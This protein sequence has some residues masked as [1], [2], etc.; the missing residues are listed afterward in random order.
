MF[1]QGHD[2]TCDYTLVTCENKGCDSK[3]LRMVLQKHLLTECKYRRAVCQLCQQE[4]VFESERV[5][6][7][8]DLLLLDI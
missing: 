7:E 5:Q 1:F 2:T 8:T 4:I 3:V 6:Y